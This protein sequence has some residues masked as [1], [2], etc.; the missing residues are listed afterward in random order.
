MSLKFINRTVNRKIIGTIIYPDSFYKAFIQEATDDV[1][2][3][4]L[5]TRCDSILS[6]EQVDRF[7]NE[8]FDF[9][10]ESEPEENV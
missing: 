5:K 7:L 6:I 10:D 1:L 9:S 8:H 2:I 4:V 3:P